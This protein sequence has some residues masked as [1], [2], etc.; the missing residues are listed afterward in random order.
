MAAK[1]TIVTISDGKSTTT[2][3]VE[4]AERLLN[5]NGTM[6]HLADEGWS[7]TEGGRLVRVDSADNAAP[8]AAVKVTKKKK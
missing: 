8:A 5:L 1:V 3:T 7:V 4:H 2:A 6:W